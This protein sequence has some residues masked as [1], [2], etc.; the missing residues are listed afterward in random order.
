V[1]YWKSSK[2]QNR[3]HK[4]KKVSKIGFSKCDFENP[5]N[6]RMSSKSGFSKCDFENPE[7]TR[8]SSKSGFSKCDFENP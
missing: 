7:N 2:S 5:E 1:P 6:T 8:M 3:I 4:R